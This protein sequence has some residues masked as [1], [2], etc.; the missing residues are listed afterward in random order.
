MK[1]SF[2]VNTGEKALTDNRDDIL[3][4][5]SVEFHVPTQTYWV[6]TYEEIYDLF[7]CRGCVTELGK[8]TKLEEAITSA[9]KKHEDAKKKWIK[10]NAHTRRNQ[11]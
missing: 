9:A 2:R 5:I 10:D 8:G 3:E 11:S 6:R 7:E 1:L 4:I